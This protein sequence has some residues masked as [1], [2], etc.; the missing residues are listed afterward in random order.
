MF[1]ALNTIEV[2]RDFDK[3][4]STEHLGERLIGVNLKREW[5]GRREK[6]KV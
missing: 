4:C 2:L 1:T 5:E 3:S 6:P